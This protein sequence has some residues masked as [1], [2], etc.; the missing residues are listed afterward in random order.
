MPH[1]LVGD[2]DEDPAEE[3]ISFLGDA[4]GPLCFP[5]LVDPGDKPGVGAEFFVTGESVYVPDFMEN[6]HGTVVID[7][8]D[9]HELFHLV[10]VLCHVGDVTVE[11]VYFSIIEVELPEEAVQGDS[12]GGRERECGKEYSAFFAEEISE[13][14]G[15]PV[16]HGEC[17]DPVF[18]PGSHGYQGFF[19]AEYVSLFPYI[20][21]WH[22]GLGDEV[23]SEEPGKYF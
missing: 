12:L 10:I 11:R 23:C 20:V 18:Y 21:G 7:T 14:M 8:R 9:G 13:G 15:N 16:F 1:D 19:V 3:G 2:L 17:M 6:D 4:A 22:I 5:G